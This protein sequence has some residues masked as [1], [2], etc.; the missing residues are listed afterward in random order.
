MQFINYL[1]TDAPQN[2]AMDA[3]LLENLKPEKPV[4]SLW[5]NKRAVIVGR[6]QNTFAEINQD[7]IQQNDVQVVRRVSGGGAVYHD[8]GNICF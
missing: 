8:M 7:Y 5:Q 4:F 2:I 3:W 1:G 6:N